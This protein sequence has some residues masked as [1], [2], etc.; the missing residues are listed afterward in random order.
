MSWDQEDLLG[1]QRSLRSTT[2]SELVASPVIRT[3]FKTERWR[4]KGAERWPHLA[5]RQMKKQPRQFN[6][7][8]EVVPLQRFL[9]NSQD[10][11]HAE[12]WCRSLR[13]KK[14]DIDQIGR[15]NTSIATVTT[16]SMFDHNGTG[17]S[18]KTHT[19]RRL[20][21]GETGPH[22]KEWIERP[23][24]VGRYGLEHMGGSRYAMNLT[25]RGCVLDS[26]ENMRPVK[27]D[28]R[29]NTVR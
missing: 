25:P 10:N 18:G 8:E 14:L 16:S 3:H 28:A 7:A 26:V 20:R 15:H 9:E 27:P 2:R 11:I 1:T 22:V 17:W 5:E 12:L 23:V 6:K 13:T 4:E 29:P 19:G 24:A 21:P